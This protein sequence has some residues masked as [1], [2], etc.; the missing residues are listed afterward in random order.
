M[1]TKFISPLFVVV[2]K[3]KYI[4]NLN[5]YRNWHFRVNNFIKIAYKKTMREQLVA[6]KGKFNKIEITYTLFIDTSRKC[7]LANVC[8]VVEKFF[9]DAMVEYGLIED[10][11]IDYI[12]KVI[13][14]YGGVDKG[15]GRVIIEIKE[16][17]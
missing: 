14:K 11:N 2:G 13:Y 8:C 12:S 6:F 16:K 1:V 7:D 3:K 10:D 9:E 4:I 5:N 15:N 17:K